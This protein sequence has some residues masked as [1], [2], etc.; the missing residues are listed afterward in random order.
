MALTLESA[1]RV[2]QRTLA[3]TRKPKVQAILKAFWS[4]HDQHKRD[5]DLQFVP[6]VTLGSAAD[7]VIAD[8]ACKVY[9]IF[10]VSPAASSTAT[11]VKGTDSA[12]TGS[13]TASEL[14]Q[15]VAGAATEIL[16]YFDGFSMASGFVLEAHTTADGGTGSSAADRA[17]G[18]VVIGAA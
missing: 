9:L 18:W 7:V 8:A 10:I 4:Y 17:N 15:K 12:T 11:F 1:V 6:F 14:V 13:D 3:E 16:A 5:P 2:K